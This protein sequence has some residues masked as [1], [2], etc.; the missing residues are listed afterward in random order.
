MLHLLRFLK[1]TSKPALT[2]AND[3]IGP[4]II[5]VGKSSSSAT[6]SEVGEGDDVGIG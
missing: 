3:V 2:I 4:M 1:Y 5:S 6:G